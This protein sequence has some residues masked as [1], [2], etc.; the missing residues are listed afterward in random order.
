MRGILLKLAVCLVPL[1][2]AAMI[3]EAADTVVVHPPSGAVLPSDM[4]APV[5]IWE[6]GAAPWIVS[7]RAGD[8]ERTFTVPGG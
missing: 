6:G 1:F 5:L 4:A 8:G 7:M 2:P 3:S